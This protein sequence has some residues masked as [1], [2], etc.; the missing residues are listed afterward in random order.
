MGKRFVSALI[1]SALGI[2]VR[3]AAHRYC[4]QL[5]KLMKVY[6]GIARPTSQL[7]LHMHGIRKGSATTC[8]PPIASIANQGDW[9]MG[10]VLDMYREFADVGDA[11]LGRCLCGLVSVL[12]PHWTVDDPVYDL[13]VEYS[14]QSMFGV[15]IARHPNSIVVLVQL[16][17]SVASASDWLLASSAQ[18]PGHPLSAVPFSKS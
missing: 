4:K 8:P 17:A 9:S 15:I 3:S 14:L 7:C 1:V 12:P 10:K 2:F 6:W 11:Y 18:C 13:D 5:Q 16:L